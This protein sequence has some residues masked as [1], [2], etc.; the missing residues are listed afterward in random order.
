GCKIR[1]LFNALDP[2][3]DRFGPPHL[4]RSEHELLANA[5]FHKRLHIAVEGQFRDVPG[6]RRKVGVNLRILG[7]QSNR[8]IEERVA[9]I[10]EIETQFRMAHD[11]VFEQERTAKRR[12]ERRPRSAKTGRMNERRQIQFLGEREKWLNSWIVWSDREVLR[13]HFPHSFE[14]TGLKK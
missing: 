11:R 5:C 1:G 2:Q 9:G 7:Q 10:L 14:T 8:L 6:D 4:V 3:P 13:S 12:T